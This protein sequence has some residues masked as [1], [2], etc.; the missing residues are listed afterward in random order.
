VAGLFDKGQE[1]EISAAVGHRLAR[2]PFKRQA[3]R[4]VFLEDQAF[5]VT[6]TLKSVRESK[7]TW[8]GRLWSCWTAQACTA[9]GG[10]CIIVF[11]H[12]RTAADEVKQRF[13]RCVCEQAGKRNGWSRLRSI[14]TDAPSSR[15]G[16][17]VTAGREPAPARSFAGRQPGRG[18]SW[19]LKVRLASARGR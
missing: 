6:T 7:G 1:F 5:K 18:W 19:K 13:G 16:R 9:T 4:L 15:H 10:L 14:H 11:T 12:M 3:G 2:R 8:I 17:N